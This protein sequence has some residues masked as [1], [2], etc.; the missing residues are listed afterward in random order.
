M[1]DD[2]ITFVEHFIRNQLH[3]ILV[4]KFRENDTEYDERMFY[5]EYIRNKNG[6]EFSISDKLMIQMLVEN[7]KKNSNE[8]GAG[9]YKYNPRLEMPTELNYFSSAANAKCEQENEVA[10]AIQQDEVSRSKTH[11]VLEKL[12]SIADTNLS[13]KKPG[14]RFDEDIKR[15][16]AYVRMLAGPLAYETIQKNLP[17]AFPSLSTVN[18]GI[19][20]IDSP[21]HEGVLRVKALSDYLDLRDLP[22]VVALSED[23]TRITGSIEYHSKSNEILGFVLPMDPKTGMPIAHSFPARN[24]DEI[25][26][27]F[28]NNTPTAHFVNVVMAQP[29]ANVPP[30]SIL[31][32]GTNSKYTAEDVANRLVFITNELKKANIDVITISSDSDPK[33]NSAMR[34]LSK[35][36]SSSA[37]LSGVDWFNMGE[38]QVPFFVQDTVHIA[39]KMRNQLL[40]TIKVPTKLPMGPN[41]YIQIKHLNFLLRNFSK[42]QHCLTATVLNPIDKQNF[43]SVLRMCNEKV[44]QLLAAHVPHSEGT[45][46]FLEMTRDIIDAYTNRHLSPLERIRKIWGAVF[47]LRIWRK[48]VAASH[49]LRTD[50]NFITTNCYACIEMNAHSLVLIMLHLRRLN[51]PQL[52]L[53]FLYQSQACESTFRKIRSMSSVFCTVVNCSIRDM[54]GRMNRIELQGDYNV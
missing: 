45:I 13:R 38:D 25:C 44:T 42:D 21:M 17:L 29:M 9:Y 46:K 5:G 1:T 31:L 8:Y 12:L 33:Y 14:Y 11:E 19:T 6:F 53:P 50:K 32:Y 20:K 7:V 23:A 2:D 24:L 16:T 22:R 15:F 49:K 30:L 54:I 27:Y 41:L 47:V 18:R 10:V 39:T 40:T 28:K 43:K 3:E 34:K 48:Y 35:L 52:F 37:L 36:G 51:S 26:E 4:A